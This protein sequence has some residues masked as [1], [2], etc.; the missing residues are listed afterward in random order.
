MKVL[1]TGASGFIGAYLVEKLSPSHEVA[2]LML[3]GESIENCQLSKIF[4]GDVTV[5]ASLLDACS[6]P[7]IVIHAAGLTKTR[8]SRDYFKVNTRGTKNIVEAISRVNPNFERFIFFSSVAAAGPAKDA[9]QPLT[10]EHE[11][12]PMDSY[13]AS[14]LAAERIICES[15]LPSTVLRLPSI[16]GGGST[17][18]LIYMRLAARRIRLITDFLDIPFSLLHARDLARCIFRMIE[19]LDRAQGLY[20]LSDGQTH[21]SRILSETVAGLFP[22][23]HVPIRIPTPLFIAA[24]SV[25]DVIAKI[26]RKPVFLNSERIR[27]LRLPY[28]CSSEKFRNQFD[29]ESMMSMEQGFRQSLAWYRKQGWL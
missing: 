28:L 19:D 21:N 8:R 14:K 16:Y 3:P 4:R 27:L 11:P 6:W 25:M 10:E 29:I 13:G 17:E 5:P 2:G 7:D 18:Y 12:R 1:I 20:F 23:T 24:G 26:S 15:Q 9:Q 22:G